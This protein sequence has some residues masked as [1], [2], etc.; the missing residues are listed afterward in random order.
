MKPRSTPRT[1]RAPPL[2]L[3][4][5]PSAPEPLHRQIGEQMRRAILEGRLKPGTRLPSSR[6][7]AQDLDCAR[8][9]VVLAFDQLVAEGYVVGQAGSAMSVAADLPDEM[10]TVPRSGTPPQG[11][12]VGRPAVARR[13][14]ALLAESPSPVPAGPPIAF[15][16]G[17]PDREAFPFALWA[18]LLEREWRRPGV[19]AASAVHP[20]G[21]AGMREAIATYLGVA[22]GFTCDP[23]SVVVTTGIRHGLSLFAQVVL[24]AGDTAWIEEPGFIGVR[25][26]LAAS[27]VRAVPVAIDGSGFS[28]EAAQAMAPEARLAVVA[29]AHHF[30]LGTVLGLQRRLE[31]LSWAERRKGWI[32][33]DDFDG[34][35]RYSGRPLPPLRSLDRAGRV[36]YF[37][38]FSKLLFPALR[39]SFLVLPASLVEATERI[40]DRVSIRAPLL[41]QGALARFIADGHLATHLRRTRQLYAGRREALLEA[42]ARHLDG[43]MTIAPDP[44]GMHVIA[45]PVPRLV[46]RFDDVAVTAAASARDLT[47]QPLSVCYAGRARQHGLILGYAG[48]P[49]A[50]ID[51]ALVKLRDVVLRATGRP[52]RGRPR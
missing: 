41:G 9:T 5:D 19:E 46:P 48:T 31:L 14:R 52:R 1:R 18:K 7:M 34:E 50:E 47:V 42:A 21:H 13:T 30:P 3:A 49:E 26:A 38:S 36:A 32:A 20:F 8:G 45:S 17:Q 44:G 33:E 25:E 35:Y 16:T 37:S 11:S 40:I 23:G 10:L 39:L 24:D 27:G 43:L 15:P 12:T 22:R 51:R 28:A 4:L 29:P 2:G 6:L